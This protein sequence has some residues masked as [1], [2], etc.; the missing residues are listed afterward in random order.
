M[1]NTKF[2][3]TVKAGYAKILNR[4]SKKKSVFSSLFQCCDQNDIAEHIGKKIGYSEQELKTAPE[5]ANLGIGCGN[6][7][8]FVSIKKGDAVLDLGSGAGFDCFL[9]AEKTGKFGKVV[10]VDITPEM[11]RQAKKNAEKTGFNNVE[12]VVGD[13]EDLPFENNSFDV[14]ISNCVIN[15]SNRKKQVFEEAYRVC[16]PGGMI[17]I[18]DVI[19]VRPLPNYILNS[20]EGYIACLAGAETKESYITAMLSAGFHNITVEKEQPF[21]LEL[22]ISDP[23]AKKIIAENDLPENEVS[24]IISSIVSVTIRAYKYPLI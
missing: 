8:S 23:I 10:G 4:K 20:V 12:F 11:V 2:K 9:A 18:S 19:L 7:L 14:I 1:N 22:M 16:K 17:V 13:I 6:P 15:L 3:A 24:D 5:G 21:P